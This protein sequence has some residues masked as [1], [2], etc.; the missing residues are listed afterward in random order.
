MLLGAACRSALTVTVV[1]VV[2]VIVAVEKLLPGPMCPALCSTAGRPP[3]DCE[4]EAVLSM[5]LISS[6]YP[7]S[8]A[9]KCTLAPRLERTDS[10]ESVFPSCLRLICD[11]GDDDGDTG[12][13]SLS[14]SSLELMYT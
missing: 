11:D 2:A 8:N 6:P 4:R 7:A 9:G 12:G 10:L 3:R 1:V 14:L 13:L 5:L